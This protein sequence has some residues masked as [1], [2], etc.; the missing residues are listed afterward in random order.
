M[1]SIHGWQLPGMLFLAMLTQRVMWG[2][3]ITLHPSLP[4]SS[5]YHILIF[6]KIDWPIEIKLYGT[7]H[8]MILCKVFAFCLEAKFTAETRSPKMPKYCILLGFFFLYLERLFFKQIW[9]LFP[10]MFLVKCSLYS[11]PTDVLVLPFSRYNGVEMR[12]VTKILQQILNFFL[13]EFFSNRVF[14]VLVFHYFF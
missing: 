3:V 10:F 13:L 7:V 1:P 9:L 6:S 11:M 14:S 8:W 5:T 4:V 2:I 12:P